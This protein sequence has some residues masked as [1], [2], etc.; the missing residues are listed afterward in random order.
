MIKREPLMDEAY[1]ASRIARLDDIVAEQ[2]RKLREH[3]EIYIKPAMFLY[4]NFRSRYQ[5]IFLG[6]SLGED[7]AQM[8]ARFPA[9]VET[10]EIYLRDK[11]AAAT[12][13]ADLD[14]YIVSLWLVGFAI[15][16][17]VD[18]ASWRRLLAC[19]GN[20]G[21]DALFE[22]LVATRTPGRKPAAGLLHAAIFQPLVDA[23]AA[24]GSAR[25]ALVKR[26][27]KAWY[28]A[29][30]STYWVDSHK[31][32][33]G[34]GF[35]GYWAVE[36]AGVVKAFGMDDTAFRDMPYYPRDLLA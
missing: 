24:E 32:P 22:A 31:G 27:L 2:N 35:F 18:D 33:K 14:E 4:T 11:E 17:K 8:E 6:Y 36:V 26:Y 23:V 5:Q 1:F 9:V 19:I 34:G 7:M 28:K 13:L 25:D 29:L 12:D 3:P 20:E 15:L 21:R 16:F 30:K 10:Y